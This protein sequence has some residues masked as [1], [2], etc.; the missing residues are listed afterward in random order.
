M[1][2]DNLLT[3]IIWYTRHYRTFVSNLIA[4]KG[5]LSIMGHLREMPFTI[6]ANSMEVF[7]KDAKFTD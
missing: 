3:L 6:A 2:A 7:T 5:I 4:E 1:V